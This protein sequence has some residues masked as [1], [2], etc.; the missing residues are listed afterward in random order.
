MVPRQPS[1]IHADGP[2]DCIR[3]TERLA[4]RV[5]K[6]DRAFASWGRGSLASGWWMMIP[7]PTLCSK[8]ARSSEMRATTESCS[9]LPKRCV[10][11]HE[12]GRD[13]EA[14]RTRAAARGYFP[15]ALEL[16]SASK[17][18]SF[19]WRGRDPSTS[20]WS[21]PPRSRFSRATTRAAT[22]DAAW[23]FRQV[24]GTELT[25]R[26]PT[27]VVSLLLRHHDTSCAT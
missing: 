17:R 19:M 27:T 2:M 1:Q 24:G 25:R 15:P 7:A 21:S 9:V 16:C 26:P 5:Q 22:R 23:L 8:G 4:S 11:T 20:R 10:R 6:S 12:E 18:D 13:V 3:K 14:G